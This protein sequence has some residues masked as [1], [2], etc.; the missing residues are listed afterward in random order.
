L[1][2]AIG[3]V[4]KIPEK[5]QEAADSGDRMRFGAELIGFVS[6]N[7]DAAKAMQYVLA[8]SLGRSMGSVNLA[9]QWSRTATLPPWA[10]EKAALA[11]FTPG[12][13]I[14]DEIFQALMDSPGGL[15][16]GKV[17]PDK[18]DHFSVIATE[19]GRINLDVPEMLEWLKE[20]EPDMEKAALK[21]DEEKYPLIMS[22]GLHIDG[23]ANTQMRD[24]A[25]NEGKKYHWFR[26]H[27]DDA[28]KQGL[29]D[30]Q[31]VRVITEA[32]EEQV[33]L[34]IDATT[35]QGYALMPHG[36][37]LVHQGKKFG[38]NANRLAKNTHRDRLAGTPFHRYVRCR[39]EPA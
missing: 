34:K 12:P 32:G 7:P 13:A 37:G 38:A 18:W 3:I 23:N 31:M 35:R 20:I 9:W 4:P 24:P 19:D 30:G 22:S 6:E 27:P 36:F 10:Q 11:G 8:K 14:G 21:A 17:D 33:E 25:W 16:V 15:I 2:D 29:E 39:V 28:A 5:L 26:M 1:A